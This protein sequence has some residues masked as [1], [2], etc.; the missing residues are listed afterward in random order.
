MELC[1]DLDPRDAVRAG[2]VAVGRQS[3]DQ[4]LGK[5]QSFESEK[6]REFVGEEG[7]VQG[8]SLQL[9]RVHP[10][11]GEFVS[12]T[13]MVEVGVRDD[14]DRVVLEQARPAS[15]KRCDPEPRVDDQVP[16]A[17]PDVPDVGLEEV[18][19]RGLVDADHPVGDDTGPIPRVQHGHRIGLGMGCQSTSFSL[20]GSGRSVPG[21]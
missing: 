5:L 8:A 13:G 6:S 12:R 19:D 16:I 21:P 3:A 4:D 7:R 20:S 15:S 11:V 1:R 2:V 10:P 17:A 18:V 14:Q 9:R